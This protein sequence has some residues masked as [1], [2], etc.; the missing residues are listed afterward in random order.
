MAHLQVSGKG[1]GKALRNKR[2]G[3]KDMK[4]KLRGMNSSFKN[5]IFNFSHIRLGSF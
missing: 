3:A 1:T 2:T 4:E 5:C